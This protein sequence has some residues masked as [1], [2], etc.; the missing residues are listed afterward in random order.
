MAKFAIEITLERDMLGTNSGNPNIMDAHVIEKQRKLIMEEGSKINKEI[1]KYLDAADITPERRKLEIEK[2]M[3]KMEERTGYKFSPEQR[4]LALVGK[5]EDL[6]ETFE[7]LDTK[8]VTVFFWDKERNLP[9]IGDHMIYGFMKAASEAICKTRGKK[10]GTILQSAAY[11]T[12]TINQHCR[13]KE[14]F[15]TF[16]KDI[17]RNADKTP[18]YN[19]RS[20]RAVT[21]QGPRVGLAKSEVVPAGA[22]LKF[23][24]TVMDGSPLITSS[25]GEDDKGKFT[26]KH[27]EEIF[28]YGQMTGLGQWRNAGNGMF[29]YTMKHL[30]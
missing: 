10:T 21:A 18:S 26:M 6:K 13:I 3:D 7:E 11:T 12:S 2:L 27:L 29:T 20:L 8:G 28:D 24:L 22:K 1:N 23:V 19:Q 15:I 25:G 5:L 17:R 30:K 14:Q 16:D 4:D 9:C